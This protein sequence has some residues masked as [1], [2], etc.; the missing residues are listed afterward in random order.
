MPLRKNLNVWNEFVELTERRN[1]FVHYGGI[2]S[3]QYLKVCEENNIILKESSLGMK[4]GANR[5]YLMNSYKCL[6]EIGVKLTQVIWRK[7]KPD[8]L[9][10]ADNSLNYFAYELLVD[11]KYDLATRLLEFAYA[12]PR[13]SSE[14][15]RRMFII[16]LAQAYK[17]SDKEEKCNTRLSKEDWSACNDAFAVCVSVLQDDFDKAYMLMKR[18]GKSSEISE[19]SYLE[20][21][22]FRNFRESLQFK[23]AFL[24]IFEH[25]PQSLEQYK[26][27]SVDA[28]ENYEIKDKKINKGVNDHQMTEL[29]AG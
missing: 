20:W 12:L 17:F 6:Y 21:P 14:M 1:L 23:K 15:H 25:E 29:K 19:L 2:T 26:K 8:E 3:S 11:K 16:N 18:L 7:L 5:N 24:E 22:V 4:L 27:L 10:Q 13:H 9:E 28:D